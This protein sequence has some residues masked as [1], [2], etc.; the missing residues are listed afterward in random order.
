[1]IFEKVICNDACDVI[2]NNIQTKDSEV[3]LEVI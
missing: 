3:S 1:M 2:Q